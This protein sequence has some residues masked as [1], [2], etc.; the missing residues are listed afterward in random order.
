MGFLTVMSLQSKR[1]WSCRKSRVHSKTGPLAGKGGRTA[2]KM[3]KMAME[4]DT[5]IVVCGLHARR[6]QSTLQVVDLRQLGFHPRW[7]VWLVGAEN[8]DENGATV[9]G[10][11]GF[12]REKRERYI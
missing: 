1:V 8:G 10:C 11:A 3:A 7:R 9:S 12:E 5:S 6:L 2:S 4:A